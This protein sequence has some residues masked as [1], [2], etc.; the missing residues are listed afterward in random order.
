MTLSRR[1]EFAARALQGL[2]A[3]PIHGD[4]GFDPSGY[5]RS[6]IKYADALIA[7]LDRTAPKPTVIC[8]V[9]DE[10]GNPVEFFDDGRKIVDEMMFGVR[11]QKSRRYDGRVLLVCDSPHLTTADARLYAQ[12]IIKLCDEIEGKL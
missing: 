2:L 7:E 10:T 9:A 3:E 4:N 12:R 5:A 11:V 8:A 1:D 6:S